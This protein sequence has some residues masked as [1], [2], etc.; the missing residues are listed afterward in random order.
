MQ[1]MFNFNLLI[2]RN[3]FLL[4][5][6]LSTLL[7]SNVFAQ[8][9][10]VAIGSWRSHLSYES[11]KAL[12]QSEDAIYFGTTQAILKVNKSDRSVE[13]LNKV[14]GL[15]DMGV[16][17][18]EYFNSEQILVVAYTNGNIDLVYDNGQIKN[19]S[20]I[21]TNSN[22]IGNKQI[23]HIYCD[24]KQIYFS[25]SFGLVI[26]DLNL[27]AFSQT[28][29]TPNKEVK[30][31]TR[32]NDTI[33]ISTTSGIYLGIDDGRNLLDFQVW[34][35]QK[36]VGGI[37]VGGYP[38]KTIISFNDK[39]YADYNDSLIYYQNGQWK[40]ITGIDRSNGDTT[41]NF[42][43]PTDGRN[44]F[45]PQFNLSKSWNGDKLLMSTQTATY[46]TLTGQNEITTHIYGGA[47]RIRDVAFDQEDKIWAAD[48]GY[49]HYN[50]SNFKL[51]APK[52]NTVA[53]MHVD[54][55]GTLWIA[56]SNY[57][58]FAP[59][60][61]RNGFFRYKEGI[62]KTYD[63]KNYPA[64]D[65]IYDCVR[66]TS[67]PKNGKIYVGSFMRGLIEMDRNDRITIHDQYSDPSTLRA[68]VGDPNNT[69]VIGL[70][71]DGDGNLW[72]SNSLTNAPLAVQKRNGEWKSI[73][74]S[75]LAE[76]KT[77]NLAID[78]NN[79]VWIKQITG[80]VVVFDPGDIDDD[81]DDRSIQ[82]GDNNTV[83]PSNKINCLTADK[84]GVIWLGTDQGVT[85]F[86]CSSNVLDGGCQGNRPVITQ[87]NFN[88]YLLEGEN[89]NDIAVDG[90]NR[91]W[92]ATN[93]GLFLLSE[94]GYNQLAYFTTE[95]SPLFEDEVSHLAIDGITGT[96]Y[97][98][99]GRGLQSLRAE[100][101]TGKGIMDKKEIAVFPHPVKPDYEGPIAITNLADMA[102][103]KITDISGRLMYETTALGGQAIWNGTDYNG[104][105]A[106]S[107]VYLVFIV[108]E[109][110]NQKAV[111]KILFLN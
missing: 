75:K 2:M 54:E 61:N 6:L 111:G 101:T 76:R 62:W 24:D 3:L 51:N 20:A 15:S 102:N 21:K 29:F 99:T 93:N 97:I 105:R 53:D 95:N 12:T 81:T 45:V 106:Q 42:W 48:Q 8:D 32:K 69:R 73:D 14:S 107:G 5:L 89:V 31:C 83:L 85:I 103:V 96:V 109:N 74:I 19:L 40:H 94:D 82:L 37:N 108:N 41:I 63:L 27:E 65:T 104:R 47:W 46:Y 57:N 36:I 66:I 7:L 56:S 25:C 100:A 10:S 59:Y 11:G 26:Y 34:E 23:Y 13:H 43:A 50:Y 90:A 52:S 4:L 18:V 58:T 49:L 33:F 55:E 35:R 98:A 30:A 22:I 71:V 67:N 87:D 44:D 80:K 60:F 110:G 79:Y 17:T 64:L 1:G 68:A 78:R 28:T 77:E 84:N 39:I 9:N 91:K 72:M 38:S 88:G 86:N 16:E 70:A 92:V